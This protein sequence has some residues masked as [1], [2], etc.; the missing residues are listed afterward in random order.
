MSLTRPDVSE[1]PAELRPVLVDPQTG[2]RLYMRT[3][4]GYVIPANS[5]GVHRLLQI[6]MAGA[7]ASTLVV[8]AAAAQAASGA[9]AVTYTLSRDA[10]VQVVVLNIAGRPVRTL[11]QD[12]LRPAGSSRVV[13]NS[14]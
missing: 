5:E 12:A 3:T 2:K 6:E 13:W 7:E 11:L 14:P 8:S 1:V 9:V 10:S 4:T